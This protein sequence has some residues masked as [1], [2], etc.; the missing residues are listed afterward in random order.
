FFQKGSTQGLSSRAFELYLEQ[1]DSTKI[2]DFTNTLVQQDTTGTK[3]IIA[4]KKLAE[5][6]NPD[7]A[8]QLAKYYVNPFYAYPV[9]KKAFNILLKYDSSADRW[10]GRLKMLL[11]DVDPRIRY[12]TFKN[13][14]KIPGA[15]ASAIVDTQLQSEYDARVYEVLSS[16]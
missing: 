6:G 10:N 7:A 9:R 11:N 1:I 3:A 4:I 5:T 15:N 16:K 13:L 14:A 12:L 8:I 2:Q